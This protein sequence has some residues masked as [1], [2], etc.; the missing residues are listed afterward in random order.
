MLVLR[1]NDLG[2]SKIWKERMILPNDSNSKRIM[3]GQIENSDIALFDASISDKDNELHE[4]EFNVIRN[5]QLHENHLVFHLFGTGRS[6]EFIEKWLLDEKQV[7]SVFL[8]DNIKIIDSIFKS[9]VLEIP[10]KSDD[11]MTMAIMALTY[12]LLEY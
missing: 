1:T 6:K 9:I 4:L 7:N 10:D 11:N 8:V 5:N 12:H 3:Y 2:L